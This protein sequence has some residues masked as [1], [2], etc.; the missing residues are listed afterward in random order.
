MNEYLSSYL[1]QFRPPLLQKELLTT[2]VKD[3]EGQV[4]PP[5]VIAARYGHV[6]CVKKILSFGAGD[7]DVDIRGD[8]VFR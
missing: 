5:L 3:G 6:N 8:V 4:C 1:Y 7:V 2:A